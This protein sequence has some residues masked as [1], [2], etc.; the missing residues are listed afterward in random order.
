MVLLEFK[1]CLSCCTSSYSC[2]TSGVLMDDTVT[3]S[4]YL[5]LSSLYLHL[6]LVRITIANSQIASD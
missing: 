3:T 4:N 5:L 6:V 2:L 1:M